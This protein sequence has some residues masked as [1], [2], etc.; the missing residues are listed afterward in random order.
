MRL[1]LLLISLV[2]FGQLLKFEPPRQANGH[3]DL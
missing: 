1:S 2:A 3:P